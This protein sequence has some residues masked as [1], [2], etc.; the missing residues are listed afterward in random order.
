MAI[1]PQDLDSLISSTQSLNWLDHPPTLYP[2]ATPPE[3]KP[4]RFLAGRVHSLRATSKATVRETLQSAWHFLKSLSMEALSESTFIFTFEDDQD[5]Q[6][7]LE[8]SPWNIRGHPLILQPWEKSMSLNE[9]D[10]TEGVYWVQVHDLPLELMTSQNAEIIGNHLGKCL[11]TEAVAADAAGYSM[12]KNFLRVKVL[13]PLRNPL[14]TGFNQPRENRHPAWV[15]LKYERLSDFCFFCGR[16][17]HTKIYCPATET[18]PSPPLFGPN[19]RAAPPPPFKID[20]IIPRHINTTSSHP[21]STPGKAPSIISLNA[22]PSNSLASPWEGAVPSGPSPMMTQTSLTSIPPL[23]AGQV[24]HP[25]T[26]HYSQPHFPLSNHDSLITP[27]VPNTPHSSQQ[28]NSL[29]TTPIINPSCDLVPCAPTN[30]LLHSP[31]CPSN[32]FPDSHFAP[33]LFTSVITDIEDISDSPIANLTCPN[34]PRSCSS[35]TEL[36]QV[37]WF[38]PVAPSSTSLPPVA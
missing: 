1:P 25:T 14:I 34:N 31:L 19:L 29:V 3:H 24:T 18:P 38:G 20:V 22:S 37:P 35:S 30:S 10:F 2:A 15:Q 13:L 26:S 28:L 17:G 12:R 7:V 6:R 21:P 5:M 36:V 11:G 8:L 23:N 9:L 33:Q 16:L 4:P 27:S 32:S